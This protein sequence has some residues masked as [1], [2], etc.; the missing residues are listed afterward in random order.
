[1]VT[2][3]RKGTY[4]CW[5]TILCKKNRRPDGPASWRRVGNRFF[6]CLHICYSW[7]CLRSVVK[8]YR[9][10]GKVFVEFIQSSKHR[11]FVGLEGTDCIIHNLEGDLTVK[12]PCEDT[13]EIVISVCNQHKENQRYVT[14]VTS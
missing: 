13:R 2:L 5:F 14:S 6:K 9:G 3:K 1:M 7:R 4:C 11:K 10:D 8:G 12:Y